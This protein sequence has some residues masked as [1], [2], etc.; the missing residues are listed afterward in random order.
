MLRSRKT[1]FDCVSALIRS[2]QK[3]GSIC[4]STTKKVS[5]IVEIKILFIDLLRQMGIKSVLNVY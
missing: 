1:V 2:A 3:L 5:R 4:R